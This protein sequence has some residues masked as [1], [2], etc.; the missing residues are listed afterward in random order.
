M[1]SA[2]HHYIPAAGHTTSRPYSPATGT[3]FAPFAV[4][5]ALLDHA[6]T[7]PHV[8]GVRFGS[9]ASMAAWVGGTWADVYAH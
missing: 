7:R 5:L 9:V 2:A 4:S 6:D 3:D 8:Q 1:T